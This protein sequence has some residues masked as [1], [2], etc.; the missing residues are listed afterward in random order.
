MSFY[1]EKCR[2]RVATGNR[3]HSCGHVDPRAIQSVTGAS[4]HST[5][6]NPPH[7]AAPQVV[8]PM[9][10]ATPVQPMY[11]QPTYVQPV[12][13]TAAQPVVVV[14]R[15]T[16]GFAIASFVVALVCGGPLAVIFGH[17]ALSQIDK[18]QEDGRGLA[19]A[20]LVIGYIS[21]VFW[22]PLFFFPV[23]L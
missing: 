8:N 23:F 16:N 3:C 5:Q 2:T 11:V 12:V 14:P 21:L 4:N 7:P 17:V 9:I 20:G 1:C 13:V 10:V 15:K 6:L 19:I 18:N 22:F